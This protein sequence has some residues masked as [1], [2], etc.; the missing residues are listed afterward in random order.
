VK[1]DMVWAYVQ[2]GQWTAASRSDAL[3]LN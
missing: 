3:F 2:D 1:T